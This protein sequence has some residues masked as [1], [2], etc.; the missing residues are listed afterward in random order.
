MKYFVYI[1]KSKKD[2]K[3]YTGSTSNVKK[4]IKWHNS[5]K[6]TSTRYRIPLYLIYLRS[7]SDKLSALKYERW[8]KKQKG[9]YKVKELINN[10]KQDKI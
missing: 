5:G 1:L 8:L 7:F 9:G 10:Q 4:R 2:G 3:N 6:N